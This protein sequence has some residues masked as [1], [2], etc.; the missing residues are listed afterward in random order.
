MTNARRL[1]SAR[2]EADIAQ[3]ILN[4]LNTFAVGRAAKQGSGVRKV[5]KYGGSAFLYGL[6]L[7]LSC[8]ESKSG[9]SA[10]GKIL[11]LCRP[12]IAKKVSYRS[13]RCYRPLSSRC[14]LELSI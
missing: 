1:L 3:W 5:K 12:A 8:D 9:A 2:L 11:G 6:V 4:G 14:S 10:L 13:L 7:L